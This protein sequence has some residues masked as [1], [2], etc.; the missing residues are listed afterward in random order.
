MKKYLFIGLIMLSVFSC[1]ERE[2]P[3]PDN[4]MPMDRMINVLIDV[5]LIEASLSSKNLPRDTGIVFYNLYKKDLYSKHHIDD[6]LYKRSFDFYAGHPMLMDKIY[7][8]VI[9]S[10]SLKEEKEGN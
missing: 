4:V 3:I 1:K 2:E 7:E 8:R 10:L 6:S 5:H 9:D